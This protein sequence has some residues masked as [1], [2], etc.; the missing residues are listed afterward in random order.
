MKRQLTIGLLILL[1]ILTVV[2][3]ATRDAQ[4]KKVEEAVNKGLPK[5]AIEALEPII[6]E[7]LAEKKYGEAVKAI[8]RKI[9]LEGTIQGNKPEEKITR[10]EKEIE[11]APAE[12]KPLMRTLLA[13]WYWHY[14]QQNKWRFMQ[15]TA[16][17]EA[18]GSD[19]TTW[20]LPRLFAEID[21]HFTSAL[22]EEKILKATPV[23]E[24]NEVLIK[25]T[26]PDAYR[27]TLYDFIA[28]EALQF[29]TSGEQAAAKPQDAFQISAESEIFAPAEQF[30]KW[31][32]DTGDTN[33]PVFKAVSLYKELLRFH[34]GDEDKSAFID[35]DI[36]R[37]VYGKNIAT[38]ENKN[39]RYMTAMRRVANQWE[40]HELAGMALYHVAKTLQEA[41]E[42]A[43]AH[44]LGRRVVREYPKSN[45]AQL[46]RHLISI[47][48]AKSA[49]IVTERVWNAPTPMIQVHYKNVES[50]YFRAIPYDWSAGVKKMR[51]P[52]EHLDH[53]QK[54]AIVKSEPVLEWSHQLPPTPDF[55]ERTASFPA[56]RGLKAGFYFIVSS[57][58]ADFQQDANQVSVADVWVSDLA[59]ILRPRAQLIEGFVLQAN[60]GEPI[61][62]VRVDG[63][64]N[65]YRA[66]KL[67]PIEAIHTDANGMFQFTPQQGHQYILRARIGEQ[68]IGA[69]SHTYHNWWDRNTARD[70]TVL[71]TDRAIY[72]PGQTIQYKGICLKVN[73]Q[74]NNYAVLEG[75]EVTVVF[76]D[77]NGQE[78]AK[79]KHR[80]ND[81]GSFTGSFPAPRD[82]LMGQMTLQVHGPQGVAHIR[83]EEYKR[84]KFQVTLDAPKTAPKLNELVSL[85]GHAMAY[86]GAA[87]DNA[88][89]KYRVVREVRW[90]QW[91]NWGWHRGGH[92]AGDQSQEIAN[93]TLTTEVDGSFTIKFVA[94]PDLSISEKDEPTFVF[95]IYADVTDSAG[96]TRSDERT[97]NVGYTALQVTLN[98]GT[99]LEHNELFAVKITT[100]SLDGEPQE[101]KGIVRIYEL[102]APEKVQ[103]APLSGGEIP[104]HRGVSTTDQNEETEPDLSD[105]N[106]WPLGKMVVER[107]FT[108]DKEG[109]ESLQFKLKSGA[110]RV[111]LETQDRFGKNVTGKLPLQVLQPNANK[112]AI[113]IPNLVVA[114]TNSYEPGEEFLALWGTGY[115]TGRAF[116]EIEHRHK[117]LRSYWTKPGR[118]QEAIK[119]AINET[120][121]GGFT[122]H[123]TQVRENRAYLTT[124]NIQ[125]P[126][127]NKELEIKW[128]HFTSKLGPNQK[129]T[130]TAVVQKRSDGVMGKRSGEGKSDPSTPKLQHSNTSEQFAAEMVATLYDKS[131][132][133]F[134]PHHWL[135]RFGIF[136]Q[137]H[138]TARPSFENSAKRFQSYRS[139]WNSFAGV[140]NITYRS[141]PPEL[142]QNYYGYRFSR[143]GGRGGVAMAEA[144]SA[145]TARAENGLVAQDAFFETGELLAL[146]PIP[147]S[148][149]EMKDK[150]GQSPE[151]AQTGE[152][153]PDLENVTAR[154]NLNETAFFFPQLTS[155]SNGVVR[156]TF[157]MPEAL[158]EWRFMGFAHDKN[159]RSGF[160]EAKA[161]TSKDLMVQ[162]NPP[163]FLREGDEVEFT[164]K[165]SNQTDTP[166]QG[167][168]RLTFANGLT[169]KSVD[170][171]LGNKST[172][173]SFDIPGM[174][175]RSFGWRI[176]APEGI[177]VLTYKAVGATSK[178]SDGEEGFL[179]VLSRRI[180]ITESLPLPIRGPGTKHFEF[181]KLLQSGKSDTLKNE[182]L[183]VQMV[184]N[185]AWYAVMA[186][187]YL[188]EFPHECSEQVFNR[189]YANALARHIAKSDPKI[190]RIFEQ[191]RGTSALDS[192]LEKNE[193]LKSVVLE[194]TPWVRQAQSESQARKNVGILF[195]DN[196]LNYETDRTLQKLAEM[197]H[198]DGAWPWF[199]GGPGNDYITLYITTGFGRVRHLGVEVNAEPAVR[200]L[201]RLDNWIDATYREILRR[202]HEDKNNL[203]PTIALY[204][205]GRSFF[206]KDKAF[207]PKP[208]EAVDYFL[209]QA[210][211]YWLQLDNRQS[212]GHLAIALNRFDDQKTARG[213][214]ASIKERSVTD[215]EMGM[216]WRDLEFSW[217]WFRA[218]IETQALMIE[219]FDEVMNDAEAVEDCKVW[220]LKQKQ[221]QDWKTT[222]ATA[223][224]VY[225]LLLRG[226]SQ[227]VSD[228]LVQVTIGG[229]EIKP[230]KVEA[231]TGFYE[232]RFT[233]PEVK[234]AMGEI[235]VKKVDEGVAWG[236]V[237]WQYMEDMSKVT[238]HE[239]TPLKLKKT[240]F[241]KVNTARG[242]E[243]QPIKGHLEVGDELV[244]RIE[245]RTDRDMEYMHMKDQR[246]SGT[247]PV[248][249][250]SRYKYQD[251]LGYYESTRDTASHF[252]ID[253]LP[254]GVYVFEYSTRVQLR[255][256]YQSGIAEI[257]CMY[258]PEFNSHSES[259]PLVVK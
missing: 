209:G 233:G 97:V 92:R 12:I 46:S 72:R 250:L 103:R 258:A 50:V 107:K 232:K 45:G 1:S 174:Q 57:H 154:K 241:K 164:V 88:Q 3:A 239:G 32:P 194:E 106:N 25:G 259:F 109:K 222:K 24:F 248:N 7:A 115:D 116:I 141:F 136:Y 86:T 197:Q 184:S 75:Q 15:R 82:R 5:S 89:V 17:A 249:V 238:P 84:P 144:P 74:E 18:P 199:P 100:Q 126:W 2:V 13:H 175:S 190:H 112:L 160:I 118:T 47:I 28:H 20:D 59:F 150:N 95:R 62:G 214:M 211:K 10:L 123:V 224:A 179:P 128:E 6:K 158:T 96:E 191:W 157:T 225:A 76:L 140:P 215:E 19:F 229:Q 44:E 198:N 113:K 142:T 230:E 237:H 137:N 67:V 193:E 251:G 77:A 120:M 254:K 60:S 240:L 36:G 125:V 133:T 159:V 234:P 143:V 203:T 121:R 110:Y 168:V 4:W 139:D 51:R 58:R 73:Q 147:G 226:T 196:R 178:V 167:K 33:S 68:E 16:T 216:F 200:S 207:E 177:S 146:S 153:E 180:F 149:R 171:L 172:E 182:G 228:A 11:T 245:L 246:G 43:K 54:E 170:D 21:K 55:K 243:L 124:Q 49:S 247:E 148:K 93:G 129:E 242:P 101:A 105:P 217:W 221:T 244:V 99:W 130:W 134:V 69:A 161:V 38:G 165:V 27:P 256:N 22:A 9:V 166:Q 40:T 183:T 208:R 71:F 192:P 41:T 56:P 173:Q 29:Y 231:G 162:P 132:D 235:T 181:T 122:L 114:T 186:L 127:S 37:L 257:Q 151:E 119:L 201:D 187:P 111:L 108:T 14:F 210:R 189:F 212:Q 152:K 31:K 104:Y 227:L 42:L 206:L 91:W 80:C 176:K 102:K 223:D 94:K 156:M 219:A 53:A 195:E 78:I 131:L 252:F 79:Q 30:M 236:S 202:G 213:I 155:D 26:L 39:A 255:G 135:Q 218:P 117:I 63:W 185:P 81:Y 70:Q 253:Y 48:E 87:V 205:Y 138:S 23:S 8:A 204:L 52:V 85:T 65:D 34:Q 66:N 163:R 64:Y 83:V 35:A 220:L 188:M 90:P 145:S 98:A 61:K 169:E